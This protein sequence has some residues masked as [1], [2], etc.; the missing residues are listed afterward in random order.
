[1]KPILIAYFSR[2]GM[3]YVSGSIQ[4]LPIGNTET[5]AEIIEE[6]THGTPFKIAPARAYPLNYHRCTEQAKAELAAGIRPEITAHLTD[7]NAFGTVILGYPNWWGTMPM[8]VWSFLEEYD[9]SGKTI[10]PFCTHEGSGIGHSQQD[11]EA[12]CPSAVLGPGLAI[13]GSAV[14]RSKPEI[15]RWLKGA[16]L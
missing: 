10:L 15:A 1:M 16:G 13:H 8:P 6:L 7:M 9:F 4:D 14:R 5:A 2:K 3:N 12:L 11:I